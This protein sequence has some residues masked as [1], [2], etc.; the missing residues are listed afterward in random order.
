MERRERMEEGRERFEVEI[1]AKESWPGIVTVFRAY[2]IFR[3]ASGE[4][5]YES[6]MRGLVTMHV[7]PAFLFGHCRTAT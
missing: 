1:E 6:C 7:M 5:G 4:L 3:S 2:V